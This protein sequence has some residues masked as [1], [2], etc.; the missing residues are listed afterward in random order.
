M[1]KR[2]SAIL[3]TAGLLCT[4]VF[5]N[6][7][8][9]NAEEFK[10]TGKIWVIGDSISSDHND[11]DNLRDNKVPITGWGNVLQNMV[12]KDVTIE[13]KARSG[14]S[15]KSYT[16]EKVYKEV[17]KSIQPGDY[18]IIQ[19]G[20]NDEKADNKGLYTDPAGDSAT[21][22]AFK[23]YLKKYYIEPF[24]QS[25]A[26]I[27]LASNVVRLYFDNDRLADQANEPYATAMK[28]LAEEC[29]Q[30]GL[31]VYFIDT[32]Q[33]TGNLYNKIG[34][35]KATALHAVLGQE[36]D[37]EVDTTHYGPL[38]AVRVAGIMAKELK[39]L[40]LECCQDITTTGMLDSQSQATARNQAEKFSWR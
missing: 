3:L 20:H 36:P 16:N 38:G 18:V 27:I 33:I 32:Y 2:V 1:K 34:E 24:T 12:S 31:N 22:G 8:A 11:E 26:R 29:K 13:N 37:T 21:E 15:S 19:F 23:N 5:G 14:R 7:S 40:G 28:E 6:A 39:A 17:K 30:E 35:E 9:L 4:A 10:E 25:G